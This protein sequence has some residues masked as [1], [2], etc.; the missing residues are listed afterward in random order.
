MSLNAIFR[1]PDVYATAIA[2][3]SVP[4]QRYYDT[5]YQERYMGLPQDN[6]DGYRNGSPITFADRLR[7]NLLLIHGSGDDNVHYQGAEALINALIAAD[8]SFSMMEYPNRS[9]GI[10]EGKNTSLHLF[11]LMTRYLLSNLTPGPVPH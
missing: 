11:S 1:Y 2:V 6:P 9:H 8:K 3:A 10:S 7:G 5:I 4:N